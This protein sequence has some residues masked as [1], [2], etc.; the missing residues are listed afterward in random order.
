MHVQ[1]MHQTVLQI[2]QP[3]E[4]AI[5]LKVANE[6]QYLLNLLYAIDPNSLYLTGSEI[7]LRDYLITAILENS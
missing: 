6:S 2:G 7:Q 1:I 4:I 5:I 3:K